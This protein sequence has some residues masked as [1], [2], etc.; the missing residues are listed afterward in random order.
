MVICTC[1][2][3]LIRMTK[4]HYLSRQH[5]EETGQPFF[6]RK[7]E[8]CDECGKLLYSVT[9]THLK[10][11]FHKSGGKKKTGKIYLVASDTDKN[12]VPTFDGL[13]YK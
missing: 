3:E 8:P 13:P 10:S 9:K 6:K 7:L 5:L 2:K 12:F 1:G 4:G 11:E